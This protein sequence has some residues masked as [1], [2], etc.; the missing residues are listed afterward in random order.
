VTDIENLFKEHSPWL[1]RWLNAKLEQRS[2]AE[3][4]S[5]DT[6]VRVLR[7]GELE[8]VNNPRAYLLTIARGLT[9]D[10]YRR[11]SLER[12]Y[13]E[14]LALLPELEHPSAETH[15]LIIESLI[16]I[17]Q[18]L[19]GLGTKVKTVFILSQF[20]GLTYVQIAERMKVSR[21][22]VVNYMAKA[23]EHCCLY[24]IEQGL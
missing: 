18:M 11:R 7:R 3:D 24:R 10:L 17:D 2:D 9:V 8:Q 16:E 19:D 5:Q 22:S 14:S 23:M 12:Q 1:Q 15:H 4:L 13:L 21:R 20:E 6:F